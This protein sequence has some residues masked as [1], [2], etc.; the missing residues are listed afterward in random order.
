LGIFSVFLLIFI[1]ASLDF[2]HPQNKKIQSRVSLNPSFLLAFV[3]ILLLTLTGDG[4]L[5]LQQ[6]NIYFVGGLE[7]FYRQR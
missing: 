5:H 6:E 4:R 2:D 7:K 3:Y 1:F